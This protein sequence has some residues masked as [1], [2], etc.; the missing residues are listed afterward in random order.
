MH[1]HTCTHA[2]TVPGVISNLQTNQLTSSS[3]HIEFTLPIIT[4]GTPI[5]HLHTTTK[6]GDDEPLIEAHPLTDAVP[7]QRRSHRLVDLKGDTPYT[8]SVSVGNSVGFGPEMTAY[9]KTL[10][11]GYPATPTSVRP[12]VGGVGT[13]S[14][15][16]SWEVVDVGKPNTEYFVR[17]L[18]SGVE[19]EGE[20]FTVKPEQLDI[21]ENTESAVVCFIRVAFR[22]VTVCVSKLSLSLSLYRYPH[23]GQRH[24]THSQS[25]SGT[26]KGWGSPVNRPISLALSPANRTPVTQVGRE[27]WQVPI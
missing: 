25:P 12:P 26:M 19:G 10:R 1:T 8:V 24:A 7:S 3:V 9:F 4:G 16:L 2:R 21:D 15:V 5:T 17:A 20:L 14:V 23:F 27:S 11:P 22:F 6:A 18:Q 13:T